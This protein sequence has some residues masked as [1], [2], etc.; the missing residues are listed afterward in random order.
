MIKKFRA[1]GVEIWAAITPPVVSVKVST[2]LSVH[3]WEFITT[4]SFKLQHVWK[5]LIKPFYMHMSA[6][7]SH[8]QYISICKL[9][10][11]AIKLRSELLWCEH[12]KFNCISKLNMLS[13][14]E[15]LLLFYQICSDLIKHV[16]CF[17]IFYKMYGN[18]F[19]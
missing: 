7:K 16:F 13:F 11:H 15:L 1:K 2:T 4:Y 17:R 18:M 5:Y 8:M 14:H 3:T 12:S 6:N 19:W 9:K 10:L